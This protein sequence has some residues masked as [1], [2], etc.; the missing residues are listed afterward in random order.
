MVLPFLFVSRALRVVARTV[1]PVTDPNDDRHR[2]PVEER[3][4]K[5]PNV[6][7]SEVRGM[8]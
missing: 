5:S 8:S 3:S 6:G 1:T 2:N 4:G 7:S